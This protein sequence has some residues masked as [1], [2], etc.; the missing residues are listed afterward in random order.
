[1]RSI[2]CKERHTNRL[3]SGE[4]SQDALGVNFPSRSDTGSRGF[5]D[6]TGRSGRVKDRGR[7]K[8]DRSVCVVCVARC[9]ERESAE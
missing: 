4:T 9:G 6:V 7:V 1:M 3:H 8:R 2:L 5:C